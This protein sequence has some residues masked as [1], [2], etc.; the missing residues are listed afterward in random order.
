LK[1]K[2]LE[3]IYEKLKKSPKIKKLSNRD[4]EEKTVIRNSNKGN[5]KSNKAKTLEKDHNRKERNPFHLSH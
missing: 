3:E 4:H 2:L 1:E 5:L